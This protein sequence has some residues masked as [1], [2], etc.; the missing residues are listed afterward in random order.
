MKEK[1]DRLSEAFV[2]AELGDPHAMRDL[3]RHLDDLLQDA[4][5]RPVV[6]AVAALSRVIDR[7]IVGGDEGPARSW[8]EVGKGIQA[9][10][11]MAAAGDPADALPFPRE[12]DADILSGFVLEAR[13]HLDA[14]DVQLLALESDSSNID[15]IHFLFRAFH[16]IKGAA[17]C[18][19]LAAMQALATAYD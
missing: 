19:D 11:E 14:A 10:V 6:E 9:L 15:A 7:L 12:F 16:T 1:L 18:L 8:E 3:R 2:L 4:P 5:P 13:E 17:G